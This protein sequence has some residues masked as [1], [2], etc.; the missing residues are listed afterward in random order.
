M[1]SNSEKIGCGSVLLIIIA[2]VFFLGLL[3]M[4]SGSLN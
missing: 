3:G 4:E 2:V 1:S